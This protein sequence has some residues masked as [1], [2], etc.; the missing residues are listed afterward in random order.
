MVA[1]NAA[2]VAENAAAIA[3]NAA[4]IADNAATIAALV[5]AIR[6]MPTLVA[7][8]ASSAAP[9][10]NWSAPD[11]RWALDE[12]AT[13]RN[14]EDTFLATGCLVPRKI[15]FWTT[16]ASEVVWNDMYAY[17]TLT[18]DGDA[19]SRQRGVCCG[20]G[21]TCTPPSCTKQ[22]AWSGGA[23]VAADSGL[24]RA[25]CRRAAARRSPRA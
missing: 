23:F 17:C 14:Y 11:H 16:R 9:G 19:D 20:N 4:T 18:R 13:G 1:E 7:A 12:E 3:G 2:A 6:G 8:E 15:D 5:D 25:D 10:G 24:P 21:E 22:T